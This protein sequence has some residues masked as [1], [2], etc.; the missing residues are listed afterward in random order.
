MVNPGLESRFGLPL[1]HLCSVDTI[2][3]AGILFDTH[4][5]LSN[6]YP[7]ELSKHVDMSIDKTTTAMRTVVERRS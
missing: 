3:D 2:N 7:T 5:T 4:Q 1:N 6:K